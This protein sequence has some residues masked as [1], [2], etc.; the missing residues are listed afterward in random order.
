M[1][2]DRYA[3]PTIEEENSYGF[4]ERMREAVPLRTL[5]QTRLDP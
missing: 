2:G 3:S 4:A 5:N 1:K